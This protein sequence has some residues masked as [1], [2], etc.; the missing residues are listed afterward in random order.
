ML[1]QFA[2]DLHLEHRPGRPPELPVA[3]PVLVLAGDVGYPHRPHYAEFLRQVGVGRERVFVVAGNHEYYGSASMADTERRIGEACAACPTPTTF[4]RGF[5]PHRHGGVT[6][7][8]DTLWSD[9]ADR[10]ARR[11]SD[12]R[13]IPGLDAPAKA[14]AM[15]WEAVGRLRALL[16]GAE[17][18]PDAAPLVLV[19][20]HAPHPDL[21]GVFRGN[22]LESA[23]A[24]DLSDLMGPP[25][26]LWIS[27]HTHQSLR[28]EKFGTRLASNCIGYPGEAGAGGDPG[29]VV[30]V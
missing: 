30:E 17:G 18:G 23:F 4:L 2:S 1:I 11:I 12:F 3:A 25:V 13:K 26:A 29:A 7:A 5:E 16:R 20:H 28:F 24:T 21:N 6:F 9:V 15:H 22:D 8:G 14:R 19:T 27:G 10:A